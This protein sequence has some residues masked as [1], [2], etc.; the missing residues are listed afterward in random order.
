M[1]F[2]VHRQVYAWGRSDYGQ[3]GLGERRDGK[4]HDNLH[5]NQQSDCCEEPTEIPQL[6]GAI[7]VSKCKQA[8]A[9]R[10][11]VV[12]VPVMVCVVSKACACKGSRLP[13]ATQLDLSQ[14]CTIPNI[15]QLM[16]VTSPSDTQQVLIH[17]L[18]S[19]AKCSCLPHN[20]YSI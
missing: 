19:V 8:H 11:R 14:Q 18:F 3:L 6:Q 17:N 1:H 2:S 7:Q 10:S 5:S 4:S 12:V 16:S 9:S 13:V 20:V 15:L